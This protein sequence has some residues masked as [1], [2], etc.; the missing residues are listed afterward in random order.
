[1]KTH[2]GK[3]VITVGEIVKSFTLKK[4]S[5]FFKVDKRILILKASKK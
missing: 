2:D 4:L 5:E 1:M 3:I